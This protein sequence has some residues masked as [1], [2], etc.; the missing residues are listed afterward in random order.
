MTRIVPSALLAGLCLF[1]VGPVQGVELNADVLEDARAIPDG[2]GYVWAGESGSPREIRHG[3]ELIVKAQA[4][5]SYCSGFT[6]CVAMET[7]RQRGLLRGK[8]PAAVR[9]FQKQWYGSTKEAAE[10]QCALAVETLGIGKEVKPMKAGRPGDFVQIWRTNKSGHSVML[11]GW[12]RD[13]REIVGIRYRSSQKSTDGVG[14][15]TEYFADVPGHDGKVDRS[16]VYV[17][18]LNKTPPRK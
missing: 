16:R 11:L 6:F 14:D 10:R 1:A 4:K 12:V 18:R 3:D 9:D 8:D 2:G 5:G 13:G 7:A 15:R 17:A